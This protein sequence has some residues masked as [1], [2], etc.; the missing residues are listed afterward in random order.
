MGRTQESRG[1]IE[2]TKRAIYKANIDIS[3]EY[4]KVSP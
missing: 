1:T 2:R 3:T 4:D